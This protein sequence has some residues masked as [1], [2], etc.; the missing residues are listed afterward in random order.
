MRTDTELEKMVL[1]AFFEFQLNWSHSYCYFMYNWFSVIL[2]YLLNCTIILKSYKM[3]NSQGSLDR[4]H[5]ETKDAMRNPLIPKTF[6]TDRY[7]SLV[8]LLCCISQ[9][10]FGPQKLFWRDQYE[11][12]LH[13]P[14]L[15][16]SSTVPVWRCLFKTYDY[17]NKVVTSSQG[18]WEGLIANYLLFILRYCIQ[19]WT[20]IL[21]LWLLSYLL[22]FH[23]V[24]EDKGKKPDRY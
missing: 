14:I 6:I 15:T 1:L 23:Q 18:R 21:S 3:E 13:F 2:P 12:F 22:S 20:L 7:L 16:A 19:E 24:E 11:L 9:L 8:Y 4:S 5:S 17:R 10:T